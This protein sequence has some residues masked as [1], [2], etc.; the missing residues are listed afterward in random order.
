MN[1][2]A[3]N[4]A[5]ISTKPLHFSSNQIVEQQLHDRIGEIEDA[6]NADAFLFLGPIIEPADKFARDY[7]EA[8]S[9]KREKLVVI[10]ETPGGYLEVA[11]RMVTVFRQHY[12]VVD[13]VVPNSAMSAGTILCMSADSI[14]MDYY[15]VLGPIDPQIPKAGGGGLVPALGYL[16]QYERLIGKAN[17][18]KLNT[19][20]MSFLLQKFDPAALYRYE[21]ERELSVSLLKE[22]LVKYKFKNWTKTKTRNMTV[23]KKYKEKRAEEIARKLNE[24]DKW[25]SHGFGISIEILRKDLNLEIEDFG[26]DANLNSRIKAYHKLLTDYALRMNH[27]FILHKKGEYFGLSLG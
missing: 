5:S 26:Q 19:A 1:L 17:R 3:K 23:T 21:Q 27:D 25:H 15:S 7:V 14:Y 2:S 11:K 18:G 4:P 13:F 8:I 22:W 12:K 16:I 9:P 20:E 10:L 24:T 6:L